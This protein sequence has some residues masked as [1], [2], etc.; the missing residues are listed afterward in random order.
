M[1]LSQLQLAQK[2]NGSMRRLAETRSHASY[3]HLVRL[4]R[5]VAKKPPAITR[6]ICRPTMAKKPSRA[7]P[8]SLR[9]TVRIHVDPSGVPPQCACQVAKPCAY[10]RRCLAC[11][12]VHPS[13]KLSHR[14][15]QHT[16]R[17][18]I[19][20]CR[21]VFPASTMMWPVGPPSAGVHRKST[22]TLWRRF[23]DAGF[24]KASS[25]T[26][27]LSQRRT[28]VLASLH[29]R[30][31]TWLS[32]G[33]AVETPEPMTRR[34]NCPGGG[35]GADSGAEP[36][37]GAASSP[38]ALMTGTVAQH[39]Q[40]PAARKLLH[41]QTA[42]ARAGRPFMDSAIALFQGGGAAAPNSVA[43]CTVQCRLGD[44][45]PHA[46]ARW[47]TSMCQLQQWSLQAINNSAFRMRQTFRSAHNASVDAYMA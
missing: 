47:P 42:E 28:A 23:L 1:H 35:G 4:T 18:S 17:A 16:R 25:H 33:T 2:Q 27:R 7:E 30:R 41:M 29:S 12:S 15:S 38:P 46:C 36:W 11:R 24:R 44:G 6:T 34:S 22:E 19:T 13:P 40:P 20:A 45:A 8:L 43:A 14:P 31:R 32:I 3:S 21:I 26:V 39:S 10:C 5:T 9:T 37:N